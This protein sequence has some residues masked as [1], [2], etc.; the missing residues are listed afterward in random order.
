MTKDEIIAQAYSIIDDPDGTIP[1]AEMSMHLEDVALDFS[2]RSRVMRGKKAV[3]YF[4]DREILTLPE[5][6]HELVRV[7]DSQGRELGPL[8]KPDLS[9]HW[10]SDTAA[11]PEDYTRDFT[12]PDQITLY[13]KPTAAGTLTLYYVQQHHVGQELLIP[14]RYHLS[15]VY[16]LA[17]KALARS[18]N[19]EDQEKLARFGTAYEAGVQAAALQASKN[20][21]SHTRRVR[22]QAF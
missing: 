9:D 5:D 20:F 19:P 6:C 17:S 8:S 2:T 22:S 21:S 18:P 15:L 10:E 1:P 14:A 16:G 13:P 4:A 11:T 7:I 12:G 3:A